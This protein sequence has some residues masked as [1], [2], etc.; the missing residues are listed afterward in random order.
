[1]SRK[2]YNYILYTGDY[3]YVYVIE[4][5]DYKCIKVGISSSPWSRLQNLQIGNPKELQLWGFYGPWFR[6]RALKIESSLHKAMSKNYLRGEWYNESP[7]FVWNFL[8]TK[9]LAYLKGVSDE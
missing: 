5:S 7:R 1:M 4:D 3:A 8:G 6:D 9:S 2:F